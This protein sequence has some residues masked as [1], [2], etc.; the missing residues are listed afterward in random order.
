M[1][2][3]V[4]QGL[5]NIHDAH[6]I[7]RY[8]PC[9]ALIFLTKYVRLVN[10]VSSRFQAL[11]LTCQLNVRSHVLPPRGCLLLPHS[12]RPPAYC[13]HSVT[14]NVIFVVR[15]SDIFNWARF[16]LIIGCLRHEGEVP[17]RRALFL[18]GLY[19]SGPDV[20]LLD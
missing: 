2:T 15:L 16:C 3:E 1:T 6:N 12:G 10:G 8:Q 18:A 4:Y 19:P 14:Y 7:G 9:A 11:V 17:L 20:A 13:G 5:Y